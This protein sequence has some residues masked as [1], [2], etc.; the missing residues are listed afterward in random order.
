[1][2]ENIMYKLL[3]PFLF[4][5]DAETSHNTMH[6]MGNFV[7]KIGF[8]TILRPFFDFEHPALQTQ[9]LGINFR[10]PVGPAAG[11]DKHG[12]LLELLPALGIGHLQVGDVSNLPH[13]GN[14]RPRL[15][16]L[17]EDRAI[18]NRMGQDNHGAE[19]IASLLK[20]KKFDVPV[21]VSLVKTPDP[22]ILG[23]AAV[24]DFV[25]C[26]IKLYPLADVSVINISCPNTAEGKTFEDPAALKTLLD[27]IIEAKSLLNIEKPIVVKISPDISFSQ[28]DEILQI[29]ENYNISG[30]ILTNTS[31]KREGLK[32]NSALM[33]N[34]GKGGLSGAPI[35]QKST[36]F[37]RYVYKKI[38]RP[39]IIG[40]G[41][42][43]SAEAAYEKIRA[44]ASLVQIFT[45]FVYEGPGLVK[46][47]K[48]GLVKLLERDGFKNISEAVGADHR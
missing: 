19:Y 41:G 12:K 28:L 21:F 9:F 20:S 23:S 45:G 14:P 39:C 18:I 27:K 47:I 15:F 17:P 8:Q 22:Q 46:K 35:K 42:V 16:R 7:S 40:L 36:E 37:V 25:N 44:G 4:K 10:N 1:M 6:D 24:E 48:K 11:F 3:R 30:Y 33:Q 26:F 38:R 29:C 13:R 43:D 34:I 32:T 31:T 2:T 5:V